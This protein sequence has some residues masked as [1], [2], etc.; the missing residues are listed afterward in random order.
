MKYEKPEITLSASAAEI[1]KGSKPGAM[2]DGLD[3][4]NPIHSTGTYESD[5]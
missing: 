4:Q 5:E 3:P 1:V 2:V